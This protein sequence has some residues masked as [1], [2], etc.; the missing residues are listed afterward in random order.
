MQVRTGKKHV[1]RIVQVYIVLK[2]ARRI[3]VVHPRKHAI[4]GVAEEISVGY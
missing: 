4:R 1:L 3:L 2:S